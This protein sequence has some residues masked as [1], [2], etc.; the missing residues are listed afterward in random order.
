MLFREPNINFESNF[1]GNHNI[2]E[3]EMNVDVNM[4][5]MGHKHHMSMSD[6][7]M[8]DGCMKKHCMMPCSPCQ[9]MPKEKCIHK[10]IIH[11]VP[12]VC[13]MHTKIINHHVFKH[14]FRPVH[15]CSEEN[16]ISNVQC[17]SCNQF[18]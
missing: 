5:P 12:H 2:V 9:E 7:S 15:T 13:P 6:M 10:T 3:N 1:A 8:G 11:E 16:M 18:R 17:G 14:T 4:M